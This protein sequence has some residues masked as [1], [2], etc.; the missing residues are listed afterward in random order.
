MTGTAT[1]ENL[2]LDSIVEQLDTFHQRATY[3]AVAALLNKSPRTLMSGRDRDPR[4]SWVVRHGT[5][6]PTGY[7]PEQMH[8]ALTERANI[9][10]TPEALRRWLDDPA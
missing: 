2:T 3:G 7:A 6:I 10:S 9:L 5:G 8:E 1:V 4:A